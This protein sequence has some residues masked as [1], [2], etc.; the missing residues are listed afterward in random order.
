[1]GWQWQELEDT[2]IICISIQIDNMP[3]PHHS[4]FYRLGALPDALPT[5]KALKAKKTVIY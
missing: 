4:I 2:Q 3:E 5:V 1:M